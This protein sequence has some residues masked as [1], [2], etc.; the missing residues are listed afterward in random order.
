MKRL[1]SIDNFR[2]I[3]IIIMIWL[4]LSDWWL[5]DGSISFIYVSLLVMQY[6]FWVSYQFISGIS[7]FL[8]YKTGGLR[9]GSSEIINNQKIK[10]EFVVRGLILLFIALLYNS[11]TAISGSNPSKIWTWFFLFTLGI[12]L[13]MITP[14]LN[15]SKKTRLYLGVVFLVT[16]FV[17]LSFLQDFKGQTNLFGIL[18]H[19]L[20]YEI[21]LHPILSSF[22]VF[23]IGTV[24]G[25]I[26]YEIYYQENKEIKLNLLKKKLIFPSTLIGGILLVF[27]VIVNSLLFLNLPTFYGII[28]TIGISLILFSGLI[29]IEEYEIFKTKK[30][31][32]FLFYFSYYSLTIYL[33]HNLLYFLFFERLDALTSLFYIVIVI[34]FIGLFLK[35]IYPKFGASISIK[36]MISKLA[37]KIVIKLEKK[38]VLEE[39]A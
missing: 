29:V 38:E 3:G 8:F 19:L 32:N 11:V 31:Y 28:S 25:D 24:V 21:G 27:I 34:V 17:F 7:R 15:T 33:V 14:L 39:E 20:Y 16:N 2:G 36:K 37:Y 9:E 26:I 13:I 6:G 4:H 1:K 12:S 23:L 30:N 18:Y 5:S 10:R 22:A 35:L